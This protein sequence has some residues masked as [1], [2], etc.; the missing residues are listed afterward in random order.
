M[1]IKKENSQNLKNLQNRNTQNQEDENQKHH[2]K[3]EKCISKNKACHQQITQRGISAATGL[4]K[5]VNTI[6]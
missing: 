2:N 6:D 4:K 5:G 1:N 3:N